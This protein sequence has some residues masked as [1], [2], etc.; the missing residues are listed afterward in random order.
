MDVCERSAPKRVLAYRYDTF[1]LPQ[2][3]DGYF[4]LVLIND[5]NADEY[6]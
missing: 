4:D 5:G 6:Q 3:R 2:Y 1:D